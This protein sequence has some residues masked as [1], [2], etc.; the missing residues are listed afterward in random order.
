MVYKTHEPRHEKTNILHMGKKDADQHRGDCEA[1]Q[2]L[3]FRYIDSM[4]R[5]S[6]LS[7]PTPTLFE[8]VGNFKIKMVK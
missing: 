2:R 6:N 1:D 7:N 4:I 5:R 8:S 3:C